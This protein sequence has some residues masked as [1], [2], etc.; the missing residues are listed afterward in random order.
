M[1]RAGRP[2]EVQRGARGAAV[3]HDRT[4]QGGHHGGE[5][6]LDDVRLDGR[7]LA[8]AADG[9]QATL[10]HGG[11]RRLVQLNDDAGARNARGDVGDVRA[12]ALRE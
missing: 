1:R 4:G 6:L 5:L 10:E 2:E 7:Q 3:Q 9:G 12:E 8:E 11:H